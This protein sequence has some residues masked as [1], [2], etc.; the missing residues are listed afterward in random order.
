M[1]SGLNGLL[2]IC[3][4]SPQCVSN[5]LTS[6]CCALSPCDLINQ[7]LCHSLECGD[8]SCSVFAVQ[9]VVITVSL[10]Q[11][12]PPSANSSAEKPLTGKIFKCHFIEWIFFYLSYLLK[13]F[14]TR[15][16][17]QQWLDT[18]MNWNKLSLKLKSLACQG[19][20]CNIESDSSS[21]TK[22]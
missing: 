20:L 5:E 2:S 12:V 15:H 16:S 22:F 6:C 21:A 10:L 14:T 11:Q 19:G 13:I 7:T 9:A 18:I 1:L 4:S 17:T 8:C 3:A